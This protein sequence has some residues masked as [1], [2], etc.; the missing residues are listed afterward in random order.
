VI[1]LLLPK[2]Q[3]KTDGMHQPAH[4]FAIRLLLSKLQT[5]T[6]GTHQPAHMFVIRLLLSK[7][8]TKTNGM[9]QHVHTFVQKTWPPNHNILID[10]ISRLALGFAINL[11]LHSQL[12]LT[13]GMQ[14]LAITL[15]TKL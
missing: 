1:K 8:Q 9:Q 12:Q 5:K 13:N 3:T 7:L 6:D 4:M 15:A 14:I 10:S 2:L 11:W